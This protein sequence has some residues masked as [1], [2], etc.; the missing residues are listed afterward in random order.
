MGIFKSDLIRA[1]AVG[2]VLGTLA[3]CAIFGGGEGSGFAGGVVPS[4]VAAPVN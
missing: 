3:I 2:F 1:F 4:A